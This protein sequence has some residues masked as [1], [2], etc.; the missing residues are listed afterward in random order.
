[1][2]ELTVADRDALR[3]ENFI[4]HA[5]HHG[6]PAPG[7]FDA[8]PIGIFEPFFIARVIETLQGNRYDFLPTS[9]TMAALRGIEVDPTTFVETSKDLARRFH[10]DDGRFKKGVLIVTTLRTG[11]R[12]LH[13]LIKLDYEDDIITFD[14]N[15]ATAVLKAVMRPLGPSPKALQ[16][17]ALV[18]LTPA[19]GNLM[20]VDHGSRADIT[21]FFQGFLDVERK[22]S[23][24][25]MTDAVTKA[26]IHTIQVHSD[27]LPV[28][29]TARAK[30]LISEAAGKDAKFASPKFCKAVFGMHG[31]AAVQ[32]TFDESLARHGIAGEVF[33][34]DKASLP[35]DGG[36][37]R[38]VTKERVTINVPEGAHD[39]VKVERDEKKGID[40]VTIRSKKVVER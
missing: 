40:T 11:A 27:T 14:V 3:V 31:T 2:K 1:M 20:V 10:K 39:T 18:E 7:L 34:F 5:V 22:F 9:E 37:R 13:S 23:A 15:N 33:E 36:A 8:V 38:Y 28:D 24:A 32:A 4:F 19:G 21:Q 35:N 29:I 26:V 30:P 6:V 16:K 25:E 17:S 12:R